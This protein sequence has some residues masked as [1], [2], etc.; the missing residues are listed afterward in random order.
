MSQPRRNPVARRTLVNVKVNIA[1]F[2]LVSACGISESE[3]R[4]LTG[5]VQGTSLPHQQ[6]LP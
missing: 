4:S 3:D 2:A 5:Q 6:A 1:A